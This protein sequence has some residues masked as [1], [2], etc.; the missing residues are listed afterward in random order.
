MFRVFA[1]AI[2]RVVLR[3]I[4]I[5]ANLQS[6]H[7]GGHANSAAPPNLSKKP[8]PKAKTTAKPADGGKRSCQIGVIPI[9]G[10]RVRRS[11]SSASRYSSNE[12]SEVPMN[13][14]GLDD[15]VGRTG[16]RSRRHRRCRF[17]GSP[18]AKERSNRTTIRKSTVRCSA[19]SNAESAGNRPEIVAANATASAIVVV[20]RV[21]GGQCSRHRQCVIDGIG[22]VQPRA[23]RS[24][25]SPSPISASVMAP[26]SAI[27]KQATTARPTRESADRSRAVGAS[28]LS[29]GSA[30]LTEDLPRHQGLA[31]ISLFRDRVRV[32]PPAAL[33]ST[34]R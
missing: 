5:G 8:A 2:V 24:S 25:C 29:D 4:R 11:R 20:H 33:L 15:L 19:I 17:E 21:Q 7:G 12:V 32:L 22:V 3:R 10:D 6:P 30:R 1:A 27:V 9:I 14:W 34:R 23:S 28:I 18:S 31:T 26:M 13:G 16:S